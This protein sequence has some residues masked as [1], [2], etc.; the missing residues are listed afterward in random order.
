MLALNKKTR[1]IKD[2]LL[3]Q[4]QIFS[5]DEPIV[6]A[7]SNGGYVLTQEEVTN[8]KSGWSFDFFAK[9]KINVLTIT[10][11][12]EKLWFLNKSC[13]DFIDYISPQLKI[14]PERL[15]YGASAG[16]LGVSIHASTLKL[17]RIL[18]FSPR[19]PN[20]KKYDLF[21]FNFQYCQDYNKD[22]TLIYDP[23]CKRDHMCALKYP[24]RTKFLRFYGVGH[25][26]IESLNGIKYLYPLPFKVR[27]LKSENCH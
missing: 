2:K 8:N 19:L 16:A 23:F 18:L 9:N 14:F 1:I 11:V 26:V 27:V 17:D 22:I 13:L 7:F 5:L 20:D 3:I 21:Q 4:Y 25:D 15:G 6:I 24:T 12:E 10:P